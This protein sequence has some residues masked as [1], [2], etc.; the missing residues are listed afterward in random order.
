MRCGYCYNPEIVY[1]VGNFCFDDFSL[2]FDERKNLLKG[3]VL[4]GGEPTIHKQIIEIAKYLKALGYK[5]KLDTNGLKPEIIKILLENTLVDYVALDFKAPK[6]KFE[7]VTKT[8][9]EKYDTFIKTLK[10]LI[11][12]NINFEVR[13]T[14]CDNLLTVHDVK[15]MMNELQNLNFIG[16]YYLQNF[17]YDTKT[18]GQITQKNSINLSQELCDLDKYKFSVSFRNF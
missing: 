11:K 9:P 1:G 15:I 5:V 16:N 8:S 3:V 4:C 18:I 2:F 6:E 7:I 10:I 17:M 12:Q 13:T 14:F